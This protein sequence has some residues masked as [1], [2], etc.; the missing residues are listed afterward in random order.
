MSPIR[1][2]TDR[3][4]RTARPDGIGCASVHWSGLTRATC[5]DATNGAGDSRS[6]TWKRGERA[7][8]QRLDRDRKRRR[9]AA[10]GL[11]QPDDEARHDGKRRRRHHDTNAIVDALGDHSAQQILRNPTR[12]GASHQE[13]ERQDRAGV[14]KPI[15]AGLDQGIDVPPGSL[16]EGLRVLEVGIEDVVDPEPLEPIGAMTD[17]DESRGRSH[18]NPLHR[19]VAPSLA[20]LGRDVS[21]VKRN[22]LRGGVFDPAQVLGFL[23]GLDDFGQLHRGR[24]GRECARRRRDETVAVLASWRSRQIAKKK[25]EIGAVEYD[26][27]REPVLG[28]APVY[29]GVIFLAEE[30]QPLVLEGRELLLEGGDQDSYLSREICLG[31]AALREERLKNCRYGLTGTALAHTADS[32]SGRRP[33]E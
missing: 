1:S 9:L 30:R 2:L 27:A 12:L 23:D 14:R 4:G 33:R 16:P 5:R 8:G 25:R 11:S 31:P 13:A 19:Q 17:R 15:E 3:I 24:A 21:A 10:R 22:A 29:V 7:S 20:A 26:A 32:G 18:H 6:R 28:D